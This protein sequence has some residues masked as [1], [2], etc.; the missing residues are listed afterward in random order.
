MKIKSLFILLTPFL[1][2]GCIANGTTSNITSSLV[3]SNTTTNSLISN[4]TISNSLTSESTS[5]QITSNIVTS[6]PVTSNPVTSTLTTSNPVTSET[7]SS[8]ITSTPTSSSSTS[9]HQ[10]IYD[11]YINFGHSHRATCIVEGCGYVLKEKCV[12]GEQEYLPIDFCYI[13]RCIK[14]NTGI[15]ENINTPPIHMEYSKVDE[16]DT[17]TIYA[18]EENYINREKINDAI[19]EG[20]AVDFSEIDEL[21]I[22]DNI[23]NVKWLSSLPNITKVTFS[24]D[25]LK[26]GDGLFTD[27]YILEKIIFEGDAPIISYSSLNSGNPRALICTSD[28]AEGFNTFLFGGLLLEKNLPTKN[29]ISSLAL[30]EYSLQSAKESSEIAKRLVAKAKEE[31]K[32]YMLYYPVENYIDNYIEIRE[33]TLELTKDCV[34]EDEKIKKIY[35]YICENIAY[36]SDHQ[37]STPYQVFKENKGVCAGY[38][39]LMHDML[40]AINVPSYYSRGV[41]IDALGSSSI[42]DLVYRQEEMDNSL[43]THAWLTVVKSNG[44]VAHY[45]PTWGRSF[46]DA[47]YQLTDEQLAKH[48]LTFETDFI[49]IYCGDVNF[50]MKDGLRQ[51]FA[52]DNN[53]YNIEFG[54][55]SKFDTSAI[56]NYILGVNHASKVWNDGWESNTS[57]EV[58]SVYDNG[59]ITYGDGNKFL[60]GKYANYDGRSL[61]IRKVFEYVNYIDEYI[62]VEIDLQNYII[63]DELVYYK[64]SEGDLCL[65]YCL[66][67]KKDVVIPSMIDGMKV[68][69]IL[70]EAFFE[71]KHVE[72]ITFED[73]IEKIIG[74][75]FVRC[76][77]LKVINLPKTLKEYAVSNDNYG[78]SG[79]CFEYCNMLEEINIDEANEYYCSKDGVLYSKDLKTLVAYPANKTSGVYKVLD[80]VTT[81]HSYAFNAARCEEVALPDSMNCLEGNAFSYSEITKITIPANCEIGY[82]AFYYSTKLRTVT[83]EDGIEALGDYSFANCQ[84]LIDIKL[85]NTL[86]NIPYCSFL[87]CLSL[88]QIELPESLTEIGY[89]AFSESGLVSI[90]LPSSLQTIGENAFYYCDKLYEIYNYSTFV[91]EKGSYDHSELAKNAKNIYSNNEESKMVIQ[92]DFLFY[93]NVLMSYVG[94][95]TTELILPNDINGEKYTISTEAFYGENVIGWAPSKEICYYE[96]PLYHPAINVTKVVIPSFIEEIPYLAFA[97]CKNIEEVH[98]TTNTRSYGINCFG[99]AKIKKVYVTGSESEFVMPFEFVGAEIIYSE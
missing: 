77:N 34:T 20:E 4:S 94:Y 54:A 27:S 80:G 72:T 6:T 3:T 74:N 55:L 61:D 86:K 21:V 83:I 97:G 70:N 87:R 88:Y 57:I 1:L 16:T 36:S 51:Y 56:Y 64:T 19:V 85:P 91:L 63:K 15:R 52:S 89:M 18:T 50:T 28:D 81:I 48:A 25:L 30:D 32:E 11:E 84:S 42:E 12:H 45:D 49:D 46:G 96:Y 14:C 69:T 26:L 41:T 82:Q 62:D 90:N 66:G 44:E 9:V 53:I 13:S 47:Y 35:D 99:G 17:L 79:V 73:G 8:S 24:D 60:H 31:N 43:D 2:A 75:A 37:T 68:T 95:G 93:E 38:V 40:C 98:I 78:E 29:D 92:G 7:T 67:N 76:S 71:N 59:I 10:H 5:S 22:G 65:F 39:T 23:I 33:F 58:G